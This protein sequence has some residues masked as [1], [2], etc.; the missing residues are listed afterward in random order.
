MVIVCCIHNNSLGRTFEV[1]NEE[2]GI[3]AIK[4]LAE[5]QLDRQLDDEELKGLENDLEVYND[6]DHDNV[7]CWAIGIVEAK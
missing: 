2:A 3:A 7:Y 5:S 1:E 4:E 6:E